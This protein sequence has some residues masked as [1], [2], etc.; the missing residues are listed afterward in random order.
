MKKLI[1]AL[2]CTVVFSNVRL[3]AQNE[4]NSELRTR[5]VQFT[6]V[7]PVGSNG[8]DAGKFINIF[9][10]NMLAGYNGGVKGCEI[11]GFSNILSHNMQGAQLAGFSNIVWGQTTGCQIA[12]FSNISKQS[13]SGCQLSGFSNIVNDS[14]SLVQIAGFI[15]VTTANSK[16]AQLAGFTNITT[17]D[18]SGVQISGFYNHARKLNGFQL[19]FINYCDSVEKGL[20]FGFISIVKHGYRGIDFGGDETLYLHGSY[21]TGVKQLYNIFSVGATQKENTI[22]WGLGY[23][24]GTTIGLSEKTAMNFEL[25]SYHIN[26][27]EWIYKNINFLHKANLKV[28]VKLTE[29]LSVYGGL[30]YNVYATNQKN[31]NGDFTDKGLI[32]WTTYSKVHKN[33]LIQMYP[34]FTAGIRIN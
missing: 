25:I 2:V 24:L 8:I 10:L 11:G 31:G 17:K 20:P 4:E 16:G 30:T 29:K 9:S 27:N 21:M 6:F 1:I 18:F 7:T 5:P 3:F 23:G 33:T 12:G 34:G 14:A 26:D 32:P 19:G 22:L 13:A 28:S 15:N